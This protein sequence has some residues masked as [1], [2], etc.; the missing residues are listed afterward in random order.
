MDVGG[1]ASQRLC[2]ANSQSLRVL[3]TFFRGIGA[4]RS[5][6]RSYSIWKIG[7]IHWKLDR[8]NRI[9]RMQN[10]K[11]RAPHPAR[12]NP[13]HHVKNYA[14]F[15]G[16]LVAAEGRAMGE[17]PTE[18]SEEPKTLA[19]GGGAG[20]RREDFSGGTPTLPENRK[21]GVIANRGRVRHDMDSI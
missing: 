1:R 10:R 3:R 18:K 7:E 6:H 5:F 4:T 21:I 14:C 19:S 8:M 15:H 11:R 20:G 13:V 17:P 16:G 12:S 2:T 9:Y